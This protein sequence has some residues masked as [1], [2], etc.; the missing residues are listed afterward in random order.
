MRIDIVASAK[1]HQ[2]TDAEIRAAVTY[3]Q[4]SLPL[5]ARRPGSRP[6]FY[7]A[8]AAA[9]QPWIEVI[10][11]LIDPTVAIAFHAM[12]LRPSVVAALGIAHLINPEFGRQR[13]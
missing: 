7:T 8:P 2:I 10:A 12:M 11:D 6:Y 5:T 1:R 3:P 4:L 13:S 9:N